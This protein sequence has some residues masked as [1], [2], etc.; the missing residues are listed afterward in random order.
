MIN[1]RAGKK[2]RQ[3]GFQEQFDYSIQSERNDSSPHTKIP[4]LDS[5]KV[6]KNIH[7]YIVKQILSLILIASKTHFSLR[8]KFCYQDFKQL[9]TPIQ[10]R[11]EYV[12]S[13]NKKN[14]IKIAVSPKY[15]FIVYEML[16]YSD[17]ISRK[18]S[19]S[20]EQQ[21]LSSVLRVKLDICKRKTPNSNIQQR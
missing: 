15:S 16:V 11:I 3:K 12:N 6:I 19:F 2:Q 20:S 18:S 9:S 5:T 8:Q 10:I 14:Q 17:K 4:E 1:E 13:D 7:G 21:G